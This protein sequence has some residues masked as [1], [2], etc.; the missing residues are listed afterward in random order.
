MRNEFTYDELLQEYKTSQ[1]K[2]SELQNK[3]KEL[4]GKKDVKV[5]RLIFDEAVSK[6]VNLLPQIV[7]QSDVEGNFLFLN[8]FALKS[9]G[10]TEKDF[11]KGINIRDV[12]NNEEDFVEYKEGFE[13]SL[14]T[15]QQK[16]NLFTLKKKD[17]TL[18]YGLVYSTV[19]IIENNNPII[20]GTVLDHSEFQEIYNK[21]VSTQM[22]L[23]E[24]N[25]AKDKLFSIIAHDL[26]NPFNA[27]SGFSELILSGINEYSIEQIEDY[28]KVIHKS[29]ANGY[30][31]LEN[32]LDWS[33]SQTGILAIK[34]ED[35]KLS[36]L[37]LENIEFLKEKALIKGL[38]LSADCDDSYIVNA[39]KNMVNT[40]LRNLV[41][42]A[43]KFTKEGTV[44]I[45]VEKNKEPGLE[46]SFAKITVKDTGI[47][48]QKAVLDKLFR[49]YESHS[50]AGTDFEQGTGLGLILCKD[51]V[52]KNGGK[53]WVDSEPEKGSSFYFTLPLQA[54]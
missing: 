8:Q 17:G 22:E 45:L 36:R 4:K 12:L 46:K 10:Y 39:D 38:E 30:Y 15:T 47:G 44:K 52:E 35:F 18:F 3:L 32:L 26:K 34:K 13:S 9:F 31:L 49:I 1:A 11:K 5:G 27:I 16:G 37:I 6:F 24:L 41:T 25:V 23:Q 33:R 43:L 29:S 20:F 40:V 50:T 14:K 28:I 7:Y 53:I 42:N 48:I 19:L 51:F 2:V 21:L 54:K